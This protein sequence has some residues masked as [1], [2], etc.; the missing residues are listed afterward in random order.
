MKVAVIAIEESP[1]EIR[2]VFLGKKTNVA[3]LAL[4]PL[5]KLTFLHGGLD[6]AN[7]SD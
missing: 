3:S 7:V 1:K 4:P 5:A 2:K 6:F